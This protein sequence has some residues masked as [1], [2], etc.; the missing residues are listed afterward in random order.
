MSLFRFNP[1]TALWPQTPII[2]A[3]RAAGRLNPYLPLF[4]V[5]MVPST[6]ALSL[7][8]FSFTFVSTSHVA[9]PRGASPTSLT[10]I[11]FSFLTLSRLYPPRS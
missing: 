2:S 9:F 4:T 8:N 3:E 6:C 10:P 7:T 5:P 11:R 1:R